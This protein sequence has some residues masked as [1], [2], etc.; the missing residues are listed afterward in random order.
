M[1][2]GDQHY[3]TIWLDAKDDRVVNVID[4]RQLPHRFVVEAIRSSADMATAIRDMHVR[5]AG[6]IGAAAGYG[7]YLAALEGRDTWNFTGTI[8]KAARQLIATRPTAVN[9]AWAVGRQL[10]VMAQGETPDDKITLALKT[11]RMIA[12][13]DV[14]QCE[15]IGI[16]G[17][18]LIESLADNLNRPVQILTHCNAGW[19]AF[20]DHGTAT[21]PIYRAFD[22]GIDL[23]VWVDETRPRN[24]GARLTAWELQQ[25]GIPH[26]VITDNAGG[27]LMQQGMIDLVITGA[28]RVTADGDVANK[29]GTY[30]KAVAAQDNGIPFYVA[31][32]E[33]TFDW[34][35]SADQIPIEQRDPDEV[36]FVS[37]S[38]GKKMTRVQITPDGTEA[39]N[40]GFDIT[41]ARLINGLITPRGICQPDRASIMAL[42]PEKQPVA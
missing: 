16:F 31:V 35:I 19:L 38:D 28:D 27:H 14:A 21:A 40:Y 41:P 29:I 30:L 20:V 26:T 11:A 13:Q 18:P 25:Q 33:A 42:F 23:H 24:Q 5:G 4:Q 2:V 7:M 15:A 22:T 3:R 36:R 32:P 9:L 37:G 12:D 34:S 10:D 8:D 1:K 17:S 39:A 6:L